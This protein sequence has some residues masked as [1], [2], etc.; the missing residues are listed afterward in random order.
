VTPTPGQLRALARKYRTLGAWRR[1]KL[2]GASAPSRT[3]F[4]AL[5][6][7]FPGALRELDTLTIDVIDARADALET[8]SD[9]LANIRAWMIWVHRYHAWM[10]AALFVRRHRS[11]EGEGSTET[12]A[13]TARAHA[14]IAVDASFVA[15]CSAPPG[16]RL[17]PVVL[18]RLA[19]ETETDPDR[20]RAALFPRLPASR[21]AIA[22]PAL[23]DLAATGA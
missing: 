10:R 7:R 18:E 3:E 16:G 17:R 9:S 6:S 4:Q 21:T 14:G 23:A 15:A 8:A 13:L 11:R 12:L 1:A 2:A 5:A 20:I 19:S 22:A